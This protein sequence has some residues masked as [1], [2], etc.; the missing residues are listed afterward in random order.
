MTAALPLQF[1]VEAGDAGYYLEVVA[2]F[3][4]ITAVIGLTALWMYLKYTGVGSEE[5][6]QLSVI[7]PQL[8]RASAVTIT[9]NRYDG[10][11]ARRDDLR[12]VLTRDY[13]TAEDA[14]E[15]TVRGALREFRRDL[16]AIVPD[17]PKLAIRG[18]LEG[19][20]ILLF[21][22]VLFLGAGWWQRALDWPGAA[23]AIGDLAHA[24]FTVLHQGASAFPVPDELLVV[25]L[26]V[27]LTAWELMRHYWAVV[28]VGLIALAV[29]FVAIDR[30][31]EEDLAVT[32][33]P[34]RRRFL[35]VLVGAPLAVWA[36]GVTVSGLT[37]MVLGPEWAARLG[38][39]AAG[40]AT[41]AALGYATADLR[42]R[43]VGRQDIPER[44]TKA[45]AGYI[46]LRRGLLVVVLAALPLLLY[47]AIGTVTTGHGATV[48]RLLTT[49][50]LP[51]QLGLLTGALGVAAVVLY[52]TGGISEFL[53]AARRL[54][55]STVLRGW[56]F[57]RGIPAIA[58]L[59]AFA[60]TWA[61]VGSHPI[62]NITLLSAI[63]GLWPPLIAAIVVGVI[64]RVW[65]LLWTRVRY[66]F[67]DFLYTR[68]GTDDYVSVACYPELEDADGDALHHARIF[69]V[70]LGH[71]DLDALLRDIEIV[72]EAYFEGDDPPAT[73]S[74]YYW[75]DVLRGTVD[76]DESK[77]ELWG[78]VLTRL[79]ASFH[80]NHGVLSSHAIDHELTQEY[81]RP[82]VDAALREMYKDS[83]VSYRDDQFIH[84]GYQ[85]QGVPSLRAKLK[86]WIIGTVLGRQV[87]R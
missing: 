19:A 73:M 6:R 36:L 20:L 24:T 69:G 30:H 53:S 52:E 83:N 46:L 62:G 51:T 22:S 28:G 59:V 39:G 8:F 42:F 29:A 81:P 87:R 66:R 65:T 48:L 45:V 68:D 23:V 26:T 49:A 17:V 56:L 11:A 57:A 33:Y 27:A 85:S 4:A 9:L 47:T 55:R 38:F 41:V 60:V 75:D 82:A 31:T 35:A 16:G 5:R 78:D 7:I 1:S 21:G 3:V 40:L 63:L 15:Q 64:V 37:G 13:Q 54:S 32:L 61:F 79:K 77:R 10:A 34:D 44:D 84:H 18:V 74:Q 58:M 50:P 80:A 12:R 67:M 14:G 2:W 86:R 25:A 70:D 72:A 71:R 76:L 43:V